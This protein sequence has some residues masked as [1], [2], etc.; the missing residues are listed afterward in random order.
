LAAKAD[1]PPA[2]QN[3]TNSLFR[4]KF[5]FWTYG[6]SGWIENSNK[7]LETWWEFSTLPSL[8]SYKPSLIS[9]RLHWLLLTISKASLG[10][11]VL[12]SLNAS[13]I[14]VWD[15]LIDIIV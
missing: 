5:S 8:S 11:I 10:V 7:P 2:A 13:L 14:S 1:L 4:S 9:I 3:S 12:T 6:L 15:D